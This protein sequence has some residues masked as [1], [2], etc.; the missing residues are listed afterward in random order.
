MRTRRIFPG[1]LALGVIC[2]GPTWAFDPTADVA[3]PA[4]AF[5]FGYS[6][7]QGGEITTAIDAIQ[8]AA[9]QG[10]VRAQWMLGHLYAEGQ[11]VPQDDR[12]AF[13]IF[14]E[15]V[16]AYARENPR[17][18]DAAFIADAFVALGHYYRGGAVAPTDYERARQLYL[19]AATYFASPAAQYELAI[20]FY[21][22]EISGA[23]PVQAVRWARLAAENGSPQ[24]Q[25]LLGHM[26]FE[27]QGVPRQAVLGLAYLTIALLRGAAEGDGARLRQ[28]HE[29]A[30]SVAT[31]AERRTAQALAE[32]WLRTNG[33]PTMLAT[34]PANPA[35][36]AALPAAAAAAPA[37]PR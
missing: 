8:Y 9:D 14:T 29:Q 21:Y 10:Y 5:R 18:P 32:D 37:A 30:F 27:G 31:Q 3:T 22:G 26:L 19:H 12:H 6:A 36:D 17:G 11:G 4:D 20:M 2:S 28:M 33:D 7:L 15:I 35:A 13:N 23:D 16:D 24:A 1:L 25:A 34:Q